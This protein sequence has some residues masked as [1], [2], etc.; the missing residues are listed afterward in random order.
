MVEPGQT[1]I[2]VASHL[3]P[4]SSHSLPEKYGKVVLL[5][6]DYSSGAER[7]RQTIMIQFTSYVSLFVCSLQKTVGTEG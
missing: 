4:F 6:L 3:L 1:W 2:L 5:W 7:Q